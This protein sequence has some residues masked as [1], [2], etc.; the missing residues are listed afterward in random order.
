VGEFHHAVQ[1]RN[2]QQQPQLGFLNP[3][4]HKDYLIVN[5]K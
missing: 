4:G 3:L 1:K 2:I 5:G